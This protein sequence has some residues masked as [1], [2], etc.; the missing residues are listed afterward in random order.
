MNKANKKQFF[1]DVFI[2]LTYKN[3]EDVLELLESFKKVLVSDYKVIIVNNFYSE[4]TRKELEHISKKHNCDF[5]PQENN[6]Y[7]A[8]NNRGIKFA[9]DHY[10]FKR[11]VISNPDIVLNKYNT[12]WFD[13]APSGVYGGVISNLNGKRQN[14]LRVFDLNLTNNT[15]YY[16]LIQHSKMLFYLSIFIAKIHRSLVLCSLRKNKRVFA[17][18]GSFF[19]ITADL[20][21]RII[22]VF[23]ENIF[24]YGEELDI[25]KKFKLLGI[26]TFF[27]KEISVIHK[28][29]GDISI[30]NINHSEISKKSCLYIYNKWKAK[31]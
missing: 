29:D 9:L 6:G 5:I 15:N 17:V 25:A 1:S 8:G 4:E 2:V 24:M 31:S 30:S 23:D 28:E 16:L 27:T 11:I 21:N 12:N 26:S 13:Q 18:H 3:T 22:P 7:G 19:L 10:D 14:P 20:L